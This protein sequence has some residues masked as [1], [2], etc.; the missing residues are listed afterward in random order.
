MLK[1]KDRVNLMDGE[2]NA[3]EAIWKKIEEL[4]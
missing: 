1:L 4:I 2:K 3:A